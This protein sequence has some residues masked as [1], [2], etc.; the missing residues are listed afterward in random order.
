MDKCSLLYWWPLVFNSGVPVPKTEIIV[1]PEGHGIDIV[2]NPKILKEYEKRIDEIAAKL[3]YPMFFRTD[4]TSGKHQWAETCF[5]ANKEML[6][7][8]IFNTIEFGYCADIIGLQCN[9]LVFREYL[10]TEF[11]FKAFNKMPITKERRLF[12]RDGVVECC[13]PY[14]PERAI[15]HADNENWKDLLD[16]TN[17]IYENDDK[18]LKIFGKKICD[19][20]GGGYW[21]IDF[22]FTRKYG[23]VLIDMAEGYCSFM[24]GRK[25][26]HWDNCPRNH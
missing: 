15:E 18:I 16:K 21:S 23:W 3:G 22:L 20:V 24:P 11:L 5:V 1:L 2:D 26:Y 13:H 17:M 10:D 12:V 19:A 7:K 8:N 6:F 9:A 25:S 4:L 14:W